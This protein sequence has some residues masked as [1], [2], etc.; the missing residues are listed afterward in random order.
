MIVKESHELSNN[1]KIVLAM[2]VVL[3]NRTTNVDKDVQINLWGE[4]PYTLIEV[5]SRKPQSFLHNGVNSDQLYKQFNL[6]RFR[7]LLQ[8]G[9]Y[10]N[11]NRVMNLDDLGKK[12]FI[13]FKGG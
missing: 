8:K 3:F 7:R 11:L 2:K 6:L 10:K 9:L 13:F 12:F 5:I 1:A 4:T